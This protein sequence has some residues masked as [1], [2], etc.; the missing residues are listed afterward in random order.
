MHPFP[1]ILAIKLTGQT[2]LP[3]QFF[4]KP[5]RTKANPADLTGYLK[6]TTHELKIG[7]KTI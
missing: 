2:E 6:I 4:Q 5:N 7:A 1:L 3:G